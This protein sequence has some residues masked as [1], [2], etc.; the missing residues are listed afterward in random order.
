[1]FITQ[2]I[3]DWIISLKHEYSLFFQAGE[4]LNELQCNSLTDFKGDNHNSTLQP[5]GRL[6]QQHL[7]PTTVDEDK[8][9]TLQHQSDSQSVSQ[10]IK[11]VHRKG[12]F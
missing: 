2:P 8:S 6:Q 12:G 5:R 11:R 9:V 1:M 3:N 7:L 10:S 4:Y